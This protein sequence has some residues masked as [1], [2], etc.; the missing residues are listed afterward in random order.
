MIR[1]YCEISGALPPNAQA[2]G[3]GSVP[4]QAVTGSPVSLAL[5]HLHL[6]P[7]CEQIRAAGVKANL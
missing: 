1:F 2:Q 4:C 7:A 5:L 6:S 3:R